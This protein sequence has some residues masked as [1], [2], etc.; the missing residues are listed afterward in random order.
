MKKNDYI[1]LKVKD[2]IIFEDTTECIV[3]ISEMVDREIRVDYSVNPPVLKIGES[4]ANVG[5]VVGVLAD[6]SVFTAPAHD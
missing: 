4:V 3:R 2:S 5:D 1:D 6:G